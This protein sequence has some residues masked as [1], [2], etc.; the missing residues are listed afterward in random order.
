MHSTNYHCVFV[1]HHS[2][3]HIYIFG[4]RFTLISRRWMYLR[5]YHIGKWWCGPFHPLSILFQLPI[6]YG[7]PG[8]QKQPLR[9]LVPIP[10]PVAQCLLPESKSAYFITSSIASQF[11]LHC[12]H[13]RCLPKKP[14]NQPL[15][16]HQK[17][18]SQRDLGQT[19]NKSYYSEVYPLIFTLEIWIVKNVKFR[20]N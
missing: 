8:K 20:S 16:T 15:R 4:S 3:C 2:G 1:T 12:R 9:N 14:I 10:S 13:K 11:T 19:F 17:L 5:P 7:A 6:P 18:I